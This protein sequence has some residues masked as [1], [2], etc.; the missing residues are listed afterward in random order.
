MVKIPSFKRLILRA[1]LRQVSPVVIRL[2]SVADQ[3]PLHN[4][5][6]CFALFIR[7]RGHAL[8]NTFA[9]YI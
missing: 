4:F 8:E 1:V 6:T 9:A 7:V 3:M 2:L 5:T